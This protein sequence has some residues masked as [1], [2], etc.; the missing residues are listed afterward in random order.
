MLGLI[1]D[2]VVEFDPI[3]TTN[4]PQYRVEVIRPNAKGVGRVVLKCDG[5]RVACGVQFFVMGP[6]SDCA[7]DPLS[8]QFTLKPG[9]S[10]TIRA[11]F[12]GQHIDVDVQ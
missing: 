7:I 12:A 5:R 4:V 2:Q 6:R 8:G 9:R 3:L 11:I 1:D 10:A